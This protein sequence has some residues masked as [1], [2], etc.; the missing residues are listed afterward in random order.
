M[1]DYVAHG[2]GLFCENLKRYLKGRKLM[3]VIIRKRGY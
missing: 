1:E 3:N 2:T